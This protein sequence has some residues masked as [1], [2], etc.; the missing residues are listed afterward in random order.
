[1][2]EYDAR[3]ALVTIRSGAGGV[4]AADLA[5]MLMRMYTRWAVHHKYPVEVFDTS[6]AVEAGMKSSTFAV[7]A[8]CAYGT[9]SFDLGTHLL[10]RGGG[11]QVR[12]V[13]RARALRLRHPLG[14][15][16]HAPPGPDQPVRQPG[17]PADLVRRRRGGPCAGADRRD[18][19]PRGG[20]EGRRLPVLGPR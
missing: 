10:C 19:D 4:V 15:G 9:R 2:G 5:E 18:R 12:H 13:R 14:R 7:H 3:E 20:R 6:C 8:P 17:P 1:S 11:H 16:G